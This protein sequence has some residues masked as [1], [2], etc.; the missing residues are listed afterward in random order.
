[1]MVSSPCGC[2]GTIDRGKDR[3]SFPFLNGKML[4]F[5]DSRDLMGPMI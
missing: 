2:V 5:M 1:M 3:M 4:I